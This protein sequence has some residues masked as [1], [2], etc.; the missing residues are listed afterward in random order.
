MEKPEPR[1]LRSKRYAEAQIEK[2]SEGSKAELTYTGHVL[3]E[4]RKA[5]SVDV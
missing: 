1:L 2:E 3:V 4:I 5:L